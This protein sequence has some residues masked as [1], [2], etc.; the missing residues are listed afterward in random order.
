MKY[1]IK[2]SFFGF[3]ALFLLVFLGMFENKIIENDNFITQKEAVLDINISSTT[4]ESFEENLEDTNIKEDNSLPF[5]EKE[6][7]VIVKE[8]REEIAN[9]QQKIIAENLE[10]EATAKVEQIKEEAEDL[11]KVSFSKI[12]EFTRTALVNIF[13]TTKNGGYFNPTTGSGIIIDKR[14]IILTNAHV[15]QYFLLKNYLTENFVDC[16]IRV[17]SPAKTLYRAK[18]IFIS[19]SWIKNNASN[20]NEDS[21]KGT[22]EDDYALLLITERTDPT[23]TISD[24]FS[25]IELLYDTENIKKG[26]SVLLAAYPA[27]FLGGIS[28]SK[29]LYISSSVVQIIDLFTFKEG[30]FDL[31]SISGSVVAQRGSSGG[32]VVNTENKLI[33]IIVTSSIEGTTAD[34]DLRAITISHINRSFIKETGFDLQTFFKG[35]MLA[36][37]NVF[38]ENIAPALTQLLVNELEK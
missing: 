24:S 25:F 37:S 23:K 29:D 18:L 22:G 7:S 27:G 21:P 13:C 4:V 12:N 26:D 34:R 19:P 28:V 5:G 35:D 6:K 9:S 8:N 10:E 20:I 36:E 14:G 31:F 1:F 17:G 33:G 38:N 11:S 30:T 32:A 15:A 2:I 16:V 3:I